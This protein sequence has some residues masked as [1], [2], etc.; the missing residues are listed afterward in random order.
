VAVAADRLAIAARAAGRGGGV[1][2]TLGARTAAALRTLAS[3][4]QLTRVLAA[5]AELE[6]STRLSPPCVAAC[7]A[8]SAPAALLSLVRACG[9]SALHRLLARKALGVLRNV[10][11]VRAGTRMCGGLGRGAVAGAS[12]G[13]IKYLAAVSAA[14]AVDTLLDALDAHRAD[15]GVVRPAV[16]ILTTLAAASQRMRARIHAHPPARLHAL[17]AYYDFAA[18]LPAPPSGMHLSAFTLS[19]TLRELDR[20]ASA[21]GSA[22]LPPPPAAPEQRAALASLAAAAP[23]LRRRATGKPAGDAPPA[24]RGVSFAPTASRER[25]APALQES[26]AAATGLPPKSPGRRAALQPADD[27]AHVRRALEW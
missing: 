22:P 17:R 26:A 9:R 3:S 15:L 10:L 5:C 1:S 6:V 24:A 16:D 7:V 19:G 11:A 25:G 27:R 14:T 18:R 2:Q 13:A 20:L 8:V 12:T 21:I 4:R 23:P